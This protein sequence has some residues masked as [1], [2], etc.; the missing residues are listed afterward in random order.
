MPLFYSF[1]MISNFFLDGLYV[2]SNLRYVNLEFN[3]LY[4]SY[5]KHTIYMLS[6][7]KGNTTNH[8]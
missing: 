7:N 6:E 5:L 8:Q 1:H 2:V 3:M 4:D